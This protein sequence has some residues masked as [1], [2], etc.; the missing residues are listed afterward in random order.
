MSI[1]NSIINLSGKDRLSQ[2]DNFRTNP[3]EVQERVL[4]NLLSSAANTEYGI[5]Y[6]FSNINSYSS[7]ASNV[8]INDYD[9]LKPYIE[10]L[11]KGE[12]NILWHSDIKWF[13]KSSGTT[14]D[15]SKYIPISREALEDSHIRSGKDIFLLYIDKFQDSCVFEGKTLSIGGS[16]DININDYNSY[17]GDL[18]A[19]IIKNL[20][21]WTFLKRIPKSDIA[22]IPDWEEKIDKIIKTCYNKKVTAFIGVPTWLL[23]LLNKM[24]DF[25]NKTNILEVWPNIELFV[26]GGV[27]FAPY[28]E[29]FNKL[30]PSDNMTYME[31]YN[32]SEGFFAIQD[33]FNRG[34]NSIDDSMLLMLDYGIFYEFIKLSDYIEGKYKVIHLADV[35]IN[36]NYAMLITTN[37]GL[38]RYLIGDTITFTSKSPYKIKITGR[39]KHFI[40]AFGE[41]VIIDNA[42]QAINYACKIT[43][44]QILEYTAAPIFY[45]QH[46][47]SQGAH[48]WLFEFSVMP[49]DINIFMDK[50]DTKLRELNSDYDAKRF[51]NLTLGQPEYVILNKGTFYKWLE[52]KGKIGGQH[53]IPRLSNTKEYVDELLEINKLIN[54]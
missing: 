27:S 15:R 35:E 52:I 21:F 46:N 48:I 41:E 47:K 12:Q 17:S 49:N 6:S 8:P 19:V 31:T 34:Y 10:R 51:K 33:N 36:E 38:W 16:T 14:A 23:V 25:T 40:N 32:A 26:H 50:L 29:Q 43:D 37:A 1:I 4:K 53:K 24:L 45:N 5:K 7:F 39:T 11:Q 2:I 18:S 54:H 9:S 30:I 3:I 20:P 42:Q 44:A 22:L 28:R 13:A